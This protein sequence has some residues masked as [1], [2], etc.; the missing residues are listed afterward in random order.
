M[1]QI[2]FHPSFLHSK[3]SGL[4][5]SDKTS[6]TVNMNKT[7]EI[8]SALSGDEYQPSRMNYECNKQ[9]PV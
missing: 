4:I 6:V 3:F 8:T 9:A 7:E 1:E 5:D 2:C